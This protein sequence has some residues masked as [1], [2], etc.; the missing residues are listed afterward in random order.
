MKF[1]NN[2]TIR[3]HSL[4]IVRIGAHHIGKQH[5]ATVIEDFG[6]TASNINSR[7]I[8]ATFAKENKILKMGC[9]EVFKPGEVED[10]PIARTLKK[11]LLLERIGCESFHCKTSIEQISRISAN[12]AAHIQYRMSG[13]G[14][15]IQ[16]F[17]SISLL[18]AAQSGDR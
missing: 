13:F 5:V 18:S 12:P 14:D 16:Q 8:L 15:C 1:P 9:F 17:Y 6:G 10:C 11:A 4:C 3:E 2:M 7:H